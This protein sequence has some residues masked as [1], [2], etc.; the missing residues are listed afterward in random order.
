MWS[1]NNHWHQETELMIVWYT[2][3]YA[4]QITPPT[5]RQILL[6]LLLLQYILSILSPSCSFFLTF[7]S[8]HS[9]Y[10]LFSMFMLISPDFLEAFNY[11]L[12]STALHR[13]LHHP[14][15]LCLAIA[16]SHTHLLSMMQCPYTHVPAGGM[17]SA[18]HEC[19]VWFIS[20]AEPE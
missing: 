10:P 15:L 19:W 16:Q 6:L 7:H 13:C 3:N 17:T 4:K 9:L 8:L 14:L 18:A 11:F 12:T 1:Q 20:K 5:T 2:Q